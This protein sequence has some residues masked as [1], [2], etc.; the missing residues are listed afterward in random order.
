V[1]N[2]L[3]IKD[4]LKNARKELQ[5][6]LD[7]NTG[8]NFEETNGTFADMEKRADEYE[9]E[10]AEPSS[11][12][13]GICGWFDQIEKAIEG[14]ETLSKYANQD[15]KSIDANDAITCARDALTRVEGEA[16]GDLDSIV[17]GVLWDVIVLLKLVRQ[18]ASNSMLGQANME[19]NDSLAELRIAEIK[20]AS[21]VK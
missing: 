14:P 2:E 8:S 4:A 21:E 20:K 10:Y 5:I 18:G 3:E 15:I 9:H 1:V 7:N 11:T 17:D 13:Q 6:L 16:G 12:I 19:L